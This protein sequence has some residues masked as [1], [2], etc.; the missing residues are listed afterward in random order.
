MIH[1]NTPQFP[2]DR[3]ETTPRVALLQK[4]LLDTPHTQTDALAHISKE[5]YDSCPEEPAVIRRARAFAAL[6]EKMPLYLRENEL[7]AGNRTPALCAQNV[8]PP[9]WWQA[10]NDP[11]TGS[12]LMQYEAAELYPAFLQLLTPEEKAAQDELLSGYP[13]GS[14]GGFGHI[15]AGYDTL[16]QKGA[17]RIAK[18]AREA[19]AQAKDPRKKE[20]LTAMA[21]AWEGFSHLGRRY[22]ALA[23][24]AMKK[25]K[26]PARRAELQEMHRI[27]EKIPAEK[28]DTFYE[29]LQAVTLMHICLLLEQPNGGSISMGGLDMILYPFYEKD[30]QEGLITR[31]QAEELMDSFYV[32]LME[33][34]VWPREVVMFA[35]LSIGGRDPQ[36]RDLTNDVSLL[37]LESTA[38]IR[39]T[40]PMLSLRWHPAM[41]RSFL[42]R[43][44][45]L[46]RMGLGLPAVFS[47]PVYEQVLQTWGLAKEDAARYGIVGCVEPAVMGMVHGQTLGGHVNLLMC[48]ELALNDGKT[49]LSGRQVGPHTGLL[50]DFSCMEDVWKAYTEQVEYACKVNVHAV[51]AAARVQREHYGYPFMSGSMKTGVPEG[52]DL[53][54][55]TVANHPTVCMV[56]VT[57]VADAMTAMEDLVFKGKKI[58]SEELLNALRCNFEGMEAVRVRL[59]RNADKFGN[60]SDR[61]VSVFNRLSR[62]Q[63]D[64]L[65]Q[66]AGPRGGYFTS[67]LWATTWH[68][69]MGEKTGASADGRRAGEPLVDGI[70]AVSGRAVHGP[71]A[72]ANDVAGIDALH[73]WEGGYTF[74]MKFNKEQL[75]TAEGLDRLT[76]FVDTF[77]SKGGMQLQVNTISR[78]VLLAAKADPEKYADLLVRVAGFSAYFCTLDDHVQD[79]IIS[80]TEHAI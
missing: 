65:R 52:M 43:A 11:R 14:A 27:L 5:A 22:A 16:L 55:G 40:H 77:F 21:I 58:S 28:P 49:L 30:L 9:A 44:C 73:L 41:D 19:A 8:V 71:T 66:Y 60:D 31:P 56:G 37:M 26:D 13:A 7:L 29:A 78:D 62:I 20:C 75:S 38:R 32:K 10:R 12:S 36:G 53:T 48:L 64:A 23:G 46:M 61:A 69:R 1:W 6:T 15:I 72:V 57:N 70:G 68:V 42:R 34:A 4:T 2:I 63:Q 80:R 74:N 33:N 18:E 17:A 76:D 3:L 54:D 45:E 24:A 67:G 35:N 50:T 39:S 25:E 47:D 59:L 51:Y 79:E